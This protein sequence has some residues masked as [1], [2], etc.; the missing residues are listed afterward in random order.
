MHTVPPFPRDPRTNQ[1]REP[2][3]VLRLHSYRVCHPTDDETQVIDGIWCCFCSGGAH[4]Y[5]LSKDNP[6]TWGYRSVER[7]LFPLARLA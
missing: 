5:C 4:Q 3:L 6:V 2:V 1:F 7:P